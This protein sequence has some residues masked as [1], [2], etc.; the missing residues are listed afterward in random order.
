MTPCR[1]RRR[2]TLL[3]GAALLLSLVAVAAAISLIVRPVTTS[4]PLDPRI[5]HEAALIARGLSGAPAPGQPNSPIAVDRVVT[6]GAST[7]VQFLF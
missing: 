5:P 1:F 2:R 3:H 4:V 6:D 7:Y